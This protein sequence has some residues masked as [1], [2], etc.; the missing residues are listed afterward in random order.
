MENFFTKEEI[1]EGDNILCQRFNKNTQEI[2]VEKYRPSKID[3]VIQQ[4][5]IVKVLKKTLDTGD[6]PHLLIHGP[7]GTG[8]T[9]TILALAKQLFGPK[10]IEDR[11]IELNASDDRGISVVRTNIISFAK[12]SIGPKDSDYPC[13]DF[14][15]IILDEA[16][17]MT[18]E[19]QAALRKIMES[20]SDITRFCFICNYIKQ[21]IDPISSRCMK[22]RFK[23]ITDKLIIDRLKNISEKEKMN[24]SKS[25]L[26]TLVKLSGGDLRQSIMCLQYLKYYNIYKNEIVPSDIVNMMGDVDERIIKKHWNICVSGNMND[27]RNSAISVNKR[28]GWNVFML[29]AHLRNCLIESDLNDNQKSNIALELANSEQRLL[30]GADDY[31]QTLN[32]FMTICKYSKN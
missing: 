14:K 2:W 21:I 8:K 24:V 19:A 6:L 9:S 27:A 10:I 28:N 5:E 31:I 3:D 12:K 29:L 30:D 18:P 13:P 4:S 16:D 7:P 22:F 32:M 23:P 11:V 1:N 20:S 17:A 15:L 26:K 25:C